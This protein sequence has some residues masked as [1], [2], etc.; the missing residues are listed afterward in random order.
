M[1]LVEM[2]GEDWDLWIF[3]FVE[4]EDWDLWIF[5]FVDS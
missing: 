4:G 5:G 1:H 2:C 3:G